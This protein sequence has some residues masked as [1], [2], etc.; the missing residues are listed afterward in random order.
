MKYSTDESDVA[1]EGAST[2]NA[3][4]HVAHF[5]AILPY[6]FSIRLVQWGK[7]SIA[8]N[9]A[10]AMKVARLLGFSYMGF[11]NHLFNLDMQKMLSDNAQLNAAVNA[12]KT[13]MVNVKN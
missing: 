13:N 11:G 10:T 7:Y 1:V 9:T 12:I 6:F 5:I 2:F 3:E 4:T 8:G